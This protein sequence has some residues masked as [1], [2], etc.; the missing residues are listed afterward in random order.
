MRRSGSAPWPSIPS[1][2][3]EFHAYRLFGLTLHSE[4]ELPDLGSVPIVPTPDI[5]IFRGSVPLPTPRLSNPQAVTGGAVISVEDVGRYAVFGGSRIVVDAD[6]GVADR[7]VRLFLLGSAMG[8]LLHQRGLLPLH[9]NAV[10]LDGRAFAFM[11]ESGAGKSTLAA[12]FYD[13]GFDTL[14]DDVCVVRFDGDG[15][16]IASPGLPRL[17][18][19]R[20]ALEASGR[21]ASAFEL[22]FTA[23]SDREK[24]DVPIRGLAEPEAAPLAAAY[25]LE[26]GDQ[27][28]VER[29]TGVA[30]AEAIFA[31]TYR[32]GYLSMAGSSE[33]HWRSCL[34][35]TRTVPVFRVERRWGLDRSDDE[36]K[37]LLDHARATG[38][39]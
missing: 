30:A 27:F 4:I 3:P 11:G 12:W 18:L 15:Q 14:A 31:N 36:N 33:V 35:L 10:A 29:L 23:D 22:S 21:D 5:E 19:W 26:R 17:R 34:A 32:G 16:A 38:A 1:P 2:V 24:Y 37:A 9:A 13:R 8:L 28:A 20:E 39:S 7:D 25:L 6:P